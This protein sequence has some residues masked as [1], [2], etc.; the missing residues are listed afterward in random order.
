MSLCVCV[1]LFI[2]VSVCIN[3]YIYLQEH[4][5]VRVCTCARAWNGN[6]RMLIIKASSLVRH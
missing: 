1:C 4:M 5:C 3:M 2:C 6:R